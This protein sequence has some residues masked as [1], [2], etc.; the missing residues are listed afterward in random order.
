MKKGRI[1]NP[2]YLKSLESRMS[3]RIV[4]LRRRRSLLPILPVQQIDEGLAD[5]HAGRHEERHRT[6]LVQRLHLA[7]DIRKKVNHLGF[8][9]IAVSEHQLNARLR[10][11][12]LDGLAD[13]FP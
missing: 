12:G 11:I 13:I 10:R 9:R 1:E 2:S 6:A 7:G 3:A 8:L 5:V 4:S